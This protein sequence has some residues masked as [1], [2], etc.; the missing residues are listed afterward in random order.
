MKYLCCDKNNVTISSLRS[1]F[2]FC[3][4]WCT[5]LFS[6]VTCSNV[7]SPYNRHHKSKHHHH[8]SHLS[9]YLPINARV[10]PRTDSYEYQ[11]DDSVEDGVREREFL[12]L[13]SSEHKVQSQLLQDMGLKKLPDTKHVSCLSSNYKT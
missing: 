4:Y 9:T 10:Q 11:P 5:L 1:W 3:V 8:I 6:N 2:L 12:S 7:E 13:K